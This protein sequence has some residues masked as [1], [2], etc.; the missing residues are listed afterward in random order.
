VVAGVARGDPGR[1]RP[2]GRR[3][4]GG[5][6]VEPRLLADWVKTEHEHSHGD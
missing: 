2:A 1:H 3:Y 4:H 5:A 6:G